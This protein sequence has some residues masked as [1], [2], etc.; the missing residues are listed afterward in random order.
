VV[1]GDGNH[2]MLSITPET[3]K[4]KVLTGLKWGLMLDLY[5]FDAFEVLL[6]SGRHARLSILFDLQSAAFHRACIREGAEYK[7]P[8]RTDGI[9]RY[10]YVLIDTILICQK[11]ECRPIMPEIKLH[12]RHKLSDIAHHKM[13]PGC[14]L[15]QPQPDTIYG[16][17]RDVE[18]PDILVSFV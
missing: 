7:I 5:A 11:V 6:K 2:G 4:Q 10:R 15:A 1:G 18:E 9:L 16:L 8:I 3:A 17:G 12:L 14:T 13:H